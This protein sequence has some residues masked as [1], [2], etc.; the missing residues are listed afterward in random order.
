MYPKGIFLVDSLANTPPKLPLGNTPLRSGKDVGE[1]VR[2]LRRERRLTQGELADQAGVGRRFLAEL[3]AGKETAQL[4]K[5]L[6]VLAMLGVV[7]T[8]NSE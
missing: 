5:A 2:R 8:G 4:G 1:L 7:V 6:R 3:E